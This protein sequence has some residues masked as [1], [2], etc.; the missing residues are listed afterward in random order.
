MS[1]LTYAEAIRDG[2]REAMQKDP[3][4]LLIGLGVPD[5]KGFFGKRQVNFGELI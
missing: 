2:Y 3:S 1:D 5:P 4:V